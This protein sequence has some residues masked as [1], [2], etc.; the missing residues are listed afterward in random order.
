MMEEEMERERMGLGRRHR[1]AAGEVQWE[2]VVRDA[3][4]DVQN[5]RLEC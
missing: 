3:K 2:R 5:I 4:S 1:K